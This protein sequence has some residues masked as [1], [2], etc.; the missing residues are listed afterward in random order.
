VSL[1]LDWIG[2]HDWNCSVKFLVIGI[3]F[4]LSARTR[5]REGS[6]EE[7]SRGRVLYPFL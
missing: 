4:F 5:N 1:V 3:V 2:I 7:R 6:F